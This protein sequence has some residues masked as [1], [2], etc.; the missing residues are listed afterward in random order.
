[1]NEVRVYSHICILVR[2]KSGLI[3]L[4][5]KEKLINR[6][7]AYGLCL[8]ESRCFETRCVRVAT[9]SSVLLSHLQAN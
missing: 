4:K 7:L 5:A 9:A 6:T 3:V 1:M 2:S 8:D